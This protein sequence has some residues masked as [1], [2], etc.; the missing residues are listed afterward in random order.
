[1]YKVKPSVT[2]QAT[3]NY[4]IHVNVSVKDI[5]ATSKFVTTASKQQSDFAISR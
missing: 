3:V 1:M 5:F 4:E 2:T